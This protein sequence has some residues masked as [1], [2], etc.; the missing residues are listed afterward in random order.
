MKERRRKKLEQATKK[1]E[2][3]EINKDLDFLDVFDGKS[4]AKS[5]PFRSQR[6]QK[7]SS[8]RHDVGIRIGGVEIKESVLKSRSP[9][10]RSNS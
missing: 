5:S 7:A 2:K 3:G 1:V 9:A 8:P 6:G 10:S 4:P